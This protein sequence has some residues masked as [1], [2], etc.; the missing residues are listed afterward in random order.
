MIE[1]FWMKKEGKMEPKDKNS[2]EW[3]DWFARHKFGGMAIASIVSAA[4]E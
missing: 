3:Q 2:H 1:L 4:E